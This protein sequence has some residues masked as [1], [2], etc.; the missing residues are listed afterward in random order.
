MT[1]LQNYQQG[2]TNLSRRDT[3]HHRVQKSV[4]RS[5][6]LE[7]HRNYVVKITSH[8]DKTH[9]LALMSEQPGVQRAALDVINYFYSNIQGIVQ[10]LNYCLLYYLMSTQDAMR[11]SI[12]LFC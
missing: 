4:I 6:P 1:H 2:M 10:N 8:E 3:L 12:E 11:R 7:S 5:I 9:F